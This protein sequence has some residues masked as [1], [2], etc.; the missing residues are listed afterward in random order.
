MEEQAKIDA[1]VENIMQA[2]R[3]AGQQDLMLMVLRKAN[4]KL[5]GDYFEKKREHEKQMIE[6][7]E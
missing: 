4:N 2:I 6:D 3:E 7:M 1:I 5:K